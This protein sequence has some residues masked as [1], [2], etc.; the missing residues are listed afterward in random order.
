MA[1]D[2]Q[3]LRNIIWRD[4]FPF[5]HIFRAFR[6]AIHPSKLVLGLMLVLA[7]YFGGRILDAV[8]YA[9]YYPSKGEINLYTAYRWSHEQGRSFDTVR[10]QD[11]LTRAQSYAALLRQNGLVSDDSAALEAA[12]RGKYFHELESGIVAERD[13]AIAEAHTHFSS[14][15][16][17][18]SRLTNDNDKRLAL[19]QAEDQ[20][21]AE[22]RQAREGAL[23]AL[24]RL[25]LLAPRPI[26]DELLNYESQQ[27]HFIVESALAGNWLGGLSN[28]TLSDS[29]SFTRGRVTSNDDLATATAFAG[30]PSVFQAVSNFTV[31]GPGWLV[32]YHF[33]YFAIFVCWFL[34]TWAIFGGAIARIAAVHVA[35]D[36]KISVRQ[37][38]RFSTSKVLS[39][40]F[41]PVIP[42]I[43]ILIAGLV[44]AVGG[45]LMYVPILGPIIVGA[46]FVLA[47]VAGFIMT[48]VVVGTGGGFN[49]MYPTIAVEGSDSFDAIS[50]SF[51]YVF[52]RPWRMLFYTFVALIYGSLTFFFCRM[53]VY[54]MLLLTHFFAGAFL[55]GQPGRFWP[56]IWP[57]V[58]DQN[59]AYHILFPGL[60]WSEKISAVLIAFWIYLLLGLLAGFVISFYFSANTI[61]YF[62]VRREVDA[63]E[64]DD[65][66]LE[67]TDDD[68]GETAAIA[69]IPGTETPS[70]PDIAAG[71]AT[72]GSSESS[73]TP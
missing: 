58:T 35:R 61:I 37:A 44:V 52:A 14:A 70:A 16:E 68:F 17:L 23:A 30:P 11:R 72:T 5:T 36:E 62:L 7:L 13:K 50:R 18:A 46:L 69:S 33:G 12:R 40:I 26:F 28:R 19:Q 34:L 29:A 2:S 57:P 42:L 45:L 64:M 27:F 55:R 32:R 48:L 21:D 24:E 73:P 15:Q 22:I 10:D 1:D 6:V 63:T 71:G 9:G 54:V 49:L 56:Q 38:L 25:T 53:F 31:V 43:I 39:F 51:S 66:Y 8:W 20:G 3:T 59:L 60:A 41:A 67:E 47:L 4:L 65:V